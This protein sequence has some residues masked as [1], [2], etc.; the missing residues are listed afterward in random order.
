MAVGE[1]RRMLLVGFLVTVFFSVPLLGIATSGL[2]AFTDELEWVAEPR[3]SHNS[4]DMNEPGFQAGSIFTDVTLS[5]DYRHTC[6]ILDDASLKCWGFNG[7]GELG[8]GGTTNQTTPQSEVDFGTEGGAVAITT[9]GYYTC[10]ILTVGSTKCWGGNGNGQLGIGSTT[11]QNT[12][13]SVDFG[14]GRTAV[15]IDAGHYHTCAILD[16]ASLRCWGYNAFGGLGIG[17]FGGS[18]TSPQAVNIGS[19]VVSIAAGTDHTCAILD[20]GT[21]KCW[22]GNGDGQLGIGSTTNQ[23]TPQ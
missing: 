19:D 10:A 18:A 13:Q 22:G 9:G 23:N 16:D 3:Y 20:D 12:P 17:N 15:V 6:A 4:P 2:N 1:S 5:A 8:T 7:N 14:S 11:N 21:L